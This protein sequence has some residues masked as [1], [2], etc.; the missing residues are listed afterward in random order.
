MSDDDKTQEALDLLRGRFLR[1]DAPAMTGCEMREALADKIKLR[2][3]TSNEFT[4]TEREVGVLL[5]ALALP[6]AH[7]VDKPVAWR[8][9]GKRGAETN[10]WFYW[11][12]EWP[13]M[14]EEQGDKVTP[15]YARPPLKDASREE[16][17]W[18]CFHCDE[19]FTDTA[20][21]KDHFGYDLLAE[22]G[23]KLNEIEG[24]LLGIVR[25]QEERLDAYHREDTASYREFYSLGADHSQALRREEEKGYAKG[26]ADGRAEALALSEHPSQD[27]GREEINAR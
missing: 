5:A 24:G 10:V 2:W 17:E 19:V 22:P 16:M 11:K 12:Q 21:A 23:C 4:F 15:L 20:A 6:P 18:R 25:R 7:E 8:V 26:L 3:D 14:H 13:Q 9:D 27:R 1:P